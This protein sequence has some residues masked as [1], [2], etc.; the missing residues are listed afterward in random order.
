[1]YIPSNLPFVGLANGNARFA[2]KIRSVV[3]VVNNR[4]ATYS[5]FC[6]LTPEGQ[7]PGAAVSGFFVAWIADQ[8][9]L[10]V[11]GTQ[12]PANNDNWRS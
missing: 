3:V 7:R 8:S 6:P 10:Q 1:M 9:S 4:K 11:S 2:S 12:N 5:C